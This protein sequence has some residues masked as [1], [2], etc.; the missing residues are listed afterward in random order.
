M[1]A[2]PRFVCW[3]WMELGLRVDESRRVN[4]LRYKLGTCLGAA[5]GWMDHFSTGN[6]PGVERK[7]RNASQLPPQVFK[8]RPRQKGADEWFGLK[9]PF[10]LPVG[11]SAHK[12]LRALAAGSLGHHVLAAGYP[13]LFG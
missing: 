3:A 11:S 13:E 8:R 1:P 4:P 7:T 10:L 6:C 2:P 9:H 12:G 5:P